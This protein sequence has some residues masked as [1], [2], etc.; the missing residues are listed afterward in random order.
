MSALEMEG[1]EEAQTP[2]GEPLC[3]PW[4]RFASWLHCICVVGFDLELG[5]TVEALYPPHAKLTDKEKTSICY[6]S[7]PDSNSGCLGDTQ[8]CFR[9]RQS[10]GRKSS[11]HCVLDQLDRDSPVYLKKDPSC[12]YG[13]VY[14]RQVRD[15]TLKRGYFQKSLVLISKL[16]YI[17]FF[18]TVVKQIAPEY[19]ERSDPCLEAACSDLD[20]WPAPLPGKTLHLPIMGLVIKVR[21]P[22]RLDK[23]GTTQIVEMTQ[24]TDAHISVSLP[25]IHE[26][27]LF[28]CFSPVF[29]HIQLLW[30]LVLLGEPLV[31]MAPSPAQSSETVL[32]LVGCISPLKY[33]SDFRP[34]FTIHD[35]EFKEYTTRTQAP[36]SVIFGVTN[37]F[38]AKTLQHWPHI[39]RIGDVKLAGDVPKQVKVKKLKTLKTLDSK[40]G[41]YSSYK[42][43]L[44]KDEEIIKQLQK[45]VQQKR[46][47]EAQNAILRRY[48]L[49]LTQS[50]IIPLER[51]VASL[52]PLLKSISAWK[53]PP[54][55][56]T[57][58]QEEFMK[59]LEKTGPQLTSRLK[60]DWIGLYRHFL[61][62][63]NFDGWFRARRKEMM[64]KLE[65]LQLEAVCNED[66]LIWVQKHSEVE[67]V[68]LV[69]KLKSKLA[70]AQRENL[71]VSVDTVQKLQGQV[72]TI[73]QE[74]PEDLQEILV[75]TNSS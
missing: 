70:L 39:I 58:S 56:K 30:E 20:R 52:M 41:V 33:C 12:F 5:Q 62:S 26:V 66:L 64:Q 16:P 59:T 27:D 74:L 73:I 7:F 75:K 14:F 61:R 68:D 11:L 2:S 19:F 4:D 48:F 23:P 24:Q 34:Y 47:S 71:P 8:F 21:I 36:P 63:P 18:N 32:A 69:L 38:F 29:F 45:G 65:A 43:Y 17:N 13:Y 37:P 51:Y 3:L 10:M 57:F 67:S 6:L 72:A 42:P 22:T 46:P 55:L 60:G 15:K 31:V 53:S 28:R 25:T 50:F 1:S 40:P 9:F 35:A 44:N 49:E 54:Q